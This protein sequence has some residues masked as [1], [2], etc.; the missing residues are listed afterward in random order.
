MGFFCSFINRLAY[1]PA[2]T[3]DFLCTEWFVCPSQCPLFIMLHTPPTISCI[4]SRLQHFS[5]ANFSLSVT[6]DFEKFTDKCN[7]SGRRI[8]LSPTKL[9]SHTV[10]VGNLC[11]LLKWEEGI[12]S[13]QTTHERIT[14]TQHRRAKD[15]APSFSVVSLFNSRPYMY[16]CVLFRK[17]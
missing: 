2:E 8:G 11:F 14:C 7:Y 12:G 17:P 6:W 3:I 13:N 15:R 5:F 10:S 1:L 16:M 4:A 9:G